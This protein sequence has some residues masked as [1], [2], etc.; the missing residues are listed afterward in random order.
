MDLSQKLSH[1][2]IYKICINI[3]LIYYMINYKPSV[4][5]TE[6]SA[7]YIEGLFSEVEEVVR[8]PAQDGNPPEIMERLAHP[9]FTYIH[10]NGDQQFEKVLNINALSQ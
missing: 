4:C 7:A 9:N 2:P 5:H 6:F 3:C 8:T 10:V 1:S